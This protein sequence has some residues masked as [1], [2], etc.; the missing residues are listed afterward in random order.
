M[1]TIGATEL[2]KN[3]DSIFDRVNEGEEIVVTHR[4]KP[5]VVIRS[6]QNNP[7]IKK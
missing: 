4:F 2:R 3:L 5:P 1:T 6:K 7:K